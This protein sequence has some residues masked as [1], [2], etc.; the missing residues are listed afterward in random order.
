MVESS[1]EASCEYSREAAAEPLS[2]DDATDALVAWVELGYKLLSADDP[3]RILSLGEFWL[4]KRR[5]LFDELEDLPQWQELQQH[6]LLQRWILVASRDRRIGKVFGVSSTIG[7]A[8][9]IALQQEAYDFLNWALATHSFSESSVQPKVAQ[10]WEHLASGKET[11]EF[12]E[13]VYSLDLTSSTDTLVL[14]PRMALRRL[15][16]DWCAERFDFHEEAPS[17]EQLQQR[18]AIEVTHTRARNPRPT[19][20]H[21]DEDEADHIQAALL[22]LRLVRFA[23][24]FTSDGYRVAR[25]GWYKPTRRALVFPKLWEEERTTPGGKH[26]ADD[27]LTRVV[28]IG[29]QLKRIT[30]AAE[31]TQRQQSDPLKVALRAYNGSFGRRDW[32]DKIVDLA[33]ALEAIAGRTQ[34]EIT[35]KVALRCAL[36]VGVGWT[37]SQRI[38]Q[39]V[40]RLYAL[41]SAIVHGNPGELRSRT[42]EFISTWP[43]K[44]KPRDRRQ[45]RGVATAI[46]LTLAQRVLIAALRLTASERFDPRRDAFLGALDR[47]ALD[48]TWRDDVQRAAGLL[49]R[50]SFT[51]PHF[52]APRGSAPPPADPGPGDLPDE[53]SE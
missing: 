34:A 2:R 21:L 30:A 4:G 35:F 19:N 36:L 24:Y 31:L 47:A 45:R 37:D 38:L 3:E 20:L 13:I 25:S 23:T 53:G 27:E 51:L 32:H 7:D 28:D 50:T 48:P 43:L 26:W 11:Y 8:P 44:R 42:E 15:T 40:T 6:A 52:V 5:Y 9:W 22:A 10:F 29:R 1:A 14:G 17:A 12:G 41:R 18:W 33:V 16:P 39:A 49:P 46:A